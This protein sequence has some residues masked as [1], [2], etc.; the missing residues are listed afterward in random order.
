MSQWHKIKALLGRNR[1]VEYN[2]S[3][4]RESLCQLRKQSET[5]CLVPTPTGSNWLGINLA[6]KQ[7]FVNTTLEIPQYYSSQMLSDKELQTLATDIEQLNFSNVIF[8]GFPLYFEKFILHFSVN[9]RKSIGVVLHGTFSEMAHPMAADAMIKPVLM[10]QQNKI[11]KLATVRE[12][13]QSFIS[14]KYSVPVFVVLNKCNI[15]MQEI[16]AKQNTDTRHIGVL[17]AD[18]FN[19]NLHNQICGASLVDKAQIHVQQK[20]NYAYLNDFRI[21]NHERLPRIEFVNLLAQMDIN[22]HLSFSESWGQLAAESMICGVPC[23]V[24]NNTN[25]LDYDEYLKNRLTVSRTDSPT[26]IAK[27]IEVV[28]EEGPAL[29]A[30]CREYMLDINKRADRLLAEF[31]TT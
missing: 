28:L 16:S 8:S 13:V 25:L 4:L 3:A 14:K 6:T 17:G 23:L 1:G 27:Q 11:G 5:I 24:S 30:K 29:G 7:L 9:Y 15:E 19:K 20:Q 12:S 31:L 26:D 10:L 21:V 22:L 18:T 2:F